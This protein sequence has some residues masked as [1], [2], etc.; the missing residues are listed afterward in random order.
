MRSESVG[1]GHINLR[2]LGVSNETLRVGKSRDSSAD[3]PEGLSYNWS[4]A[5]YEM[6]DTSF[7]VLN[8]PSSQTQRRIHHSHSTIPG[9]RF[10]KIP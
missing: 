1:G 7:E 10:G 8:S 5:G 6:L 2:R 9:L 3:I 4:A